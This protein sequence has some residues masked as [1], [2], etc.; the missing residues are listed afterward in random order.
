VSFKVGHK[1]SSLALATLVS[2]GL[3]GSLTQ[4]ALAAVNANQIATAVENAKILSNNT[5]VVAALNGSE[6]YV[7]TFRNV[8]AND[9]D[10]KIEAVLI[11]KTAMDM[12]P[13]ITRA[14]VYFYN[15]HNRYKRKAVSVTVGDVKAFGAGQL[16]KEQLLGSLAIKDEDETD[17][18]SRLSSYLQQRETQRS[19]KRIDTSMTGDTVQ[20]IADIDPD[21]SERDMKYE[22][23]KIA[24]KALETA[25][26]SA[27]TVKISFADPAMRGSYKQIEFDAPSLKRLDLSMQSTLMPVQIN[28]INTKV[29]VQSLS[30]VDGADKNLR[31]KALSML[32]DFDS[33]GVG[34]GPF[35]KSFFDIE[36]MISL[37]D[38]ENAHTAIGKLIT[39]LDEQAERA[40]NAKEAKPI[41]PAADKPIPQSTTPIKAGPKSRFG[42][43][44]T[45][46]D[47]DILTDAAKAVKD[48]ED[49]LGGPRNPQ[50][51]SRMVSV[52]NRVI[53]VLKQ[54]NRADEAKKYEDMLNRLPKQ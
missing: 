28:S 19:R 4:P 29:D 38:E 10:C 2:V 21:M 13:E 40:K 23:L 12:A 45:M 18:A 46:P 9:N 34:I 53:S 47:S 54:N 20:V 22:A 32:K 25:G 30:T 48:Q 36:Q 51:A 7:S 50:F 14:N 26:A 52:Y 41:K 33:K 16:G 6:L 3:N 39:S 37:G 5:R 35:L 24:E 15:L 1:F 42:G 49:A 44:G 11:A 17:P 43:A 31:D 27:R 8:K